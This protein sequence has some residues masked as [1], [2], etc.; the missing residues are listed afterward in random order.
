M[1]ELLSV[2]FNNSSAKQNSKHATLAAFWVHS[3]NVKLHHLL[4]IANQHNT[5]PKSGLLY[6][7]PLK[8]LL[9]LSIKVSYWDI[10]LKKNCQFEE[11]SRVDVE[12]VQKGYFKMFY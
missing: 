1:D 6:W 11:G 5:L 3:C 2:E 9:K 12:F 10:L 8:F 7:E 4:Y